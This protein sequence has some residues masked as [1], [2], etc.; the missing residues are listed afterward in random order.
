MGIVVKSV[1][2]FICQ[3]TSELQTTVHSA[4]QDWIIFY[5]ADLGFQS[6]CNPH[7]WDGARPRATGLTLFSLLDVPHGQPCPFP[8]M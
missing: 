2:I 7:S 1:R 3:P 6:S 8:P 5:A 4:H